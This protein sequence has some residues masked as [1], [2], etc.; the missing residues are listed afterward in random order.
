MIKL[1][2]TSLTVL[3]LTL[4]T[5]AALS[6]Q[7]NTSVMSNL[8]NEGTAIAADSNTQASSNV[9]AGVSVGDANANAD[10]SGSA[11]IMAGVESMLS[12]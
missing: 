4:S 7:S 2:S 5:G 9:S 6:A 1:L 11:S 12:L 10:V 3:F 8:G